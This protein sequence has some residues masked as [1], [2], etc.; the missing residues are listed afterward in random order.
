V[1]PPRPRTVTRTFL[2]MRSPED[3][4]PAR[5]PDP[6]PTLELASPPSGALSRELYLAVGQPWWWTDRQDWT[7]AEWERWAAGSQTWVGY[8]EAERIG[9]GE[10]HPRDPGE[11]ELAYFG[12][13]PGWTGR[14][15][16]GHLLTEVVRR[17]W[18]WP[19]TRR[20]W[21]STGSLDSPA[22]LP[23]YLKR[24]F[25]PFAEREEPPPK[26]PRLA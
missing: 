12:L 18:E 1:T 16:G 2:E 25:V 19:G 5:V 10:L 7:D 4:R 21:L 15:F 24:G 20:L 6:A 8:L 9:Y 11:V 17:A 14:G 26:P 3:L 23:G 13:L 22:A